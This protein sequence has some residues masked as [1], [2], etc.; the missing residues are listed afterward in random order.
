MKTK[1]NQFL[2]YLIWIVLLTLIV[3]RSNTYAQPLQLGNIDLN[4]CNSGSITN[5]LDLIAKAGQEVSLCIN[6]INTSKEDATLNIDFLDSAITQ[7][8]GKKRACNAADRPKE[9][10]GNFMLDYDKTVIIKGNSTIQKTYK[11][12]LP[13][14]YKGLSHGCIAYNVMNTQ[15]QEGQSMLNI[16]VR[17]IKFIDIFVG[18]TPIKSQIKIG[19]IKTIKDGKITNFQIQFKNIGNTR[20]NAIISGTISN[21]FG[22]K[23]NIKLEQNMVSLE[24]DQEIQIK[25]NNKDLIL[26]AYKGFFRVDFEVSNKPIFN[27]NISPGNEIP[28]EVILGGNFKISKTI[29]ISNPYFFGV[30]IVFLILIYLSLFRKRKKIII[31][32]N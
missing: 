3:S 27:F 10:F 16:I 9:Y 32:K 31:S 28:K 22:F 12:Q 1:T 5:E 18:D 21:I 20:Q 17:K 25:T 8:D 7:D 13:I 19:S 2:V 15:K 6:F 29:F 11:I 30:L 26:P 4:F 14:G 24:P 23:N